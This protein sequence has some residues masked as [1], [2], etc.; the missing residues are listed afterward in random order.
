MEKYL[1]MSDLDRTLLNKKSRISWRSKL[2]IKKLERKGHYFIMAT[3]RPYQGSL[4]FIKNLKPSIIVCDNGGSIHFIHEPEK[5]IFTTIPKD[6]FLGFIKE[7]KPYILAGMSSDYKNICMYNPDMLPFWMKHIDESRKVFTGDLEDILNHNPINPNLF[8]KRNDFNK[9][10]SLLDT[11]YSDTLGYRF[12]DNPD[13]PSFISLEIFNRKCDK[14][15]A[16][17]TLKQILN[18]KEQNDLA[19]GDSL[20]D[21]EM[22]TH[23]HNGVAM[24][25]ARPEVKKISKYITKY[26]NYKNGEIRFIKK[27][28]KKNKAW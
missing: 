6:L 18:I 28:L 1:I 7:I 22:L 11:K 8:I 19:F 13:F 21:I 25:N 17:D 23:A 9:V 16:L 15:I 20:N 14:G 3:G 10:T 27:F 24:I 4:R 12:W 5:S 2:F 26:P